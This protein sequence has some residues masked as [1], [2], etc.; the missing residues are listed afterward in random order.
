M[1]ERGLYVLN[2]TTP[3]AV[4]VELG[5]IQNQS[6]LRRLVQPDNREALAKWLKDGIAKDYVSNK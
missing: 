2:H 6:D 3:V 5:N 4:F 1:S